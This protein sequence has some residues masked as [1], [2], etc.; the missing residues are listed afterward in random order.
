MVTQAVAPSDKADGASGVVLT[1]LIGFAGVAVAIA[2]SALSTGS[3]TPRSVIGTTLL[4][5][6]ALA[7][8]VVPFVTDFG[9]RGASPG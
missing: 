6:G 9:R 2:S 7:V 5:F 3:G 4:A 1:M 8:A